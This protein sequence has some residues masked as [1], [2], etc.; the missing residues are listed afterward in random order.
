MSANILIYGDT[1][2]YIMK[3][4]IIAFAIIPRYNSKQDSNV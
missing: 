4:G 1:D 3:N 2:K